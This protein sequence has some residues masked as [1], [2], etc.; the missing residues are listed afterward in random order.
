MN[1]INSLI[2]QFGTHH[3]YLRN[4]WI[5]N[6]QKKMKKKKTNEKTKNTKRISKLIN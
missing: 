5:T 1:G 2:N 4:N 6:C 3:N